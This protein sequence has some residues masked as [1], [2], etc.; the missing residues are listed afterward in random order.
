MK[1]QEATF[2]RKVTIAFPEA[3]GELPLVVFEG[4]WTGKDYVVAS[5]A[6][7]RGYRRHV[8]EQREE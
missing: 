5:H 8:K 3:P 6:L 2:L 1:K 7:L 4:R